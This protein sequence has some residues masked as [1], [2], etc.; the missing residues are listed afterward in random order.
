MPV[1]DDIA[2]Q[3]ARNESN[4]GSKAAPASGSATSVS[5]LSLVLCAALSAF[6]D[7]VTARPPRPPRSLRPPAD[8]PS[9]A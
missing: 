9:G 7:Q 1:L 2:A 4:T 5:E 3:V 8:L 6:A